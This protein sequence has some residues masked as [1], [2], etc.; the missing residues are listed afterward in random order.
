MRFP[1]LIPP[2]CASF[3]TAGACL[4]VV[5]A[6]TTLQPV[7]PEQLTGANPPRSVRVI[8]ADHSTVVVD[9]PQVVGDTLVG[10]ADG[11]RQQ[12]PLSPGTTI[13]TRQA[14]PARTGALVIGLAAAAALTYI[15][16]E[17]QSG[18]SHCDGLCPSPSG[19][20]AICCNSRTGPL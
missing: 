19:G 9:V 18:S 5:A 16:A 10:I 15:I 20:S 3:A 2:V 6:C 17:Q 1:Y 8:R 14:A 12:F 4:I 7:R 11:V 13:E